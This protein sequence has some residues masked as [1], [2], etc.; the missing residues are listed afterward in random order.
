MIL[1]SYKFEIGNNNNDEKIL[2]FKSSLNLKNIIIKINPFGTSRLRYQR[3][4]DL[5]DI[6]LITEN[7]NDNYKLVIKK[8][9][10]SRKGVNS[11]LFWDDGWKINLNLWF[12]VKLNIDL[13]TSSSLFVYF[14]NNYGTYDFSG[15]IT[16]C[17]CGIV[18]PIYNRN[19]YVNDFLE[20]IKKSDLSNTI[21]ILMDE[22][23]TNSNEDDNIKTHNLV[24]NF[25][26]LQKNCILIKIYKNK[27]GNMFDSILHGM[28]F[29][30][31]FCPF[32]ITLDS[33]TIHKPYWIS[34][35]FDTYNPLHI[36]SHVLPLINNFIK[37]ASG[38]LK[39]N[40][41]EP[42]SLLNV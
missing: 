38:F 8:T 3:E 34:K 24:K 33:D 18:I 16:S 31:T 27:H 5:F 23:I 32:L 39:F 29:L 19:N 4:E 10:N 37:I 35:L 9:N 22:S 13:L 20:S 25:Q 2:Y 1:D 42:L 15:N 11:R 14:P 30:Y 17:K 28:D 40:N 21:I 7:N 12:S 41:N 6:N 36:S 26:L